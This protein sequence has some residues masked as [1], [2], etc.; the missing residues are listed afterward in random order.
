MQLQAGRKKN[1]E[2]DGAL[3]SPRTSTSVV[4][5]FQVVGSVTG[6]ERKCQDYL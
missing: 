4:S 1:Y 3:G 6:R 2:K 5:C